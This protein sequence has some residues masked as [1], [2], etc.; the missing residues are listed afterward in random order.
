MPFAVK[1]LLG[2]VAG[3]AL[4]LAIAAGDPATFGTLTRLLDTIG[5]MFI[6]AIRMT[7][8]PLV[9]SSLIAGVN[10]APDAATIGRLGGRAVTFFVV[11]TTIAAVMSIVLGAPLMARISLDRMV[12]DLIPFVLVILACLMIIT[13]VPSLSLGLRDLVYAK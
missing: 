8:I 4:G 2:L 9:V 1:V 13:Y 7:V 6:A 12:K 3:F 10:R 5:T 11:A